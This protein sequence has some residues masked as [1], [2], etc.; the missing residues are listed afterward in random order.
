MATLNAVIVPAKVLSDGRH[1]IR[2]SVSHNGQTRYIL[3]DIVI[4]SAREFKNGSIVRRHDAGYLN[5][6]LRG[7][8]QQYQT[9]IDEI[10]YID[11]LTCAE[12]VYNI[13][14]HGRT[15]HR[16]LQSLYEEFMEVSDLKPHTA[17]VYGYNWNV[18]RRHINTLMMAENVTRAT[19]LT[20]EK[21]LRKENLKSGTIRNYLVTV[22]IVI[23]FA[24]RCGYVSYPVDPFAQYKM[25]EA[26]VRDSWLSVE[27]V[28]LIRDFKPQKK[29]QEICRDIFMLSYY[30]G[31]INITDLI[32][33]DFN[34]QT[35]T[36]TYSRKKTDTR[37]KVNKYVIFRIPEEA[38]EI[39]KRYKGTDGRI[40]IS[41]GQRR[42][43]LLNSWV[44]YHLTQIAEILGLPQ[45]VYYSARKSFSQHA[46]E[47][48]I[49]TSIID[50]ILGHK[51][52]K[53]G[54]SLYA[55]L[56]VTP[57]KASEA[58]RKVLDN[59]K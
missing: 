31:G 49:P 59:L 24:K 14:A 40:S 15:K 5:T 11:G 39:I 6:K 33:I 22:Q 42:G 2:I 41:K 27:E 51:L 25:P 50:F 38:K 12:L 28:R 21:K 17:A 8:L 45:L 47:L 10:S 36:L 9:A 1:K 23:S 54:T 46:F 43:T 32:D 29:K 18:I 55:Y 58:V 48:G 44:K 16:T 30:L 57:E 19:I 20:L 35:D 7:L 34:E 56:K 52:D 3:S 37:K 13:K 53:G 26:E 4:D